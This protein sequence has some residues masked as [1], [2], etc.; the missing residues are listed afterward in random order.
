MK[1]RTAVTGP[2]GEVSRFEYDPEGN[3]RKFIDPN[4]NV[5]TFTYDLAG[6]LT[7]KKYADSK[8]VS[9]VYNKAGLVTQRTDARGI[10]TDYTY[11]VNDNLTTINYSDETPDGTLTYDSFNRLTKMV[12]GTGTSLF[13]YDA[14]GRLTSFDGP[15]ASDT[16]TYTYDE[17]GRPGTLSTQG[18]RSLNYVYDTLNRLAT[19]QDGAEA[20]I[21]SYLN[22]RSPLVAMLT[23]PSGS[24]TEYT[25]SLLGQLTSIHNKDSAGAVISSHDFTYN[26]QDRRD[27]ETISGLL[28]APTPAEGLVEYDYNNLNQLLAKTDPAQAFAYDADGNMTMGYTP[29]GY[30]FTASYDAENRL[31]EIEYTDGSASLRRIEYRYR[32]DSFLAEIR[33]YKN[34]ALVDATRIVRGPYLDLQDRTAENTI[35]NDYLWG[36][37]LGGGIGGL[38]NLRQGSQGYD[39]LYDGIGNVS[40]L[41]DA[42]Q[43]VVASYRYETFGKLL[44]KGGSLDQPFQFSTKRYE[45][46]VG[47]NYYGYRFYAPDLGRWMNR[48]PLGEAG[49]INLYSFVRNNAVNWVDPWG[50]YGTSSC[51]YYKQACKAT[52]R[53]YEC[54]AAQFFCPQFPSGDEGVGNWS[55]CVRQCLQELHKYRNCEINPSDN[56]RDHAY[57]FTSCADNPENPWDPSGP[58]LPDQDISYD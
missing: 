33:R 10:R 17:L 30:V 24:A 51:E 22:A 14:N 54:G 36:L 19:I 40:A 56:A 26:Q 9:Y 28:S 11:D 53:E 13:A 15:L 20:Y 38:L 45:P 32:A 44:A 43:Q 31:K 27:S 5:T 34:T 2:G 41:L 1:R 57:C 47:L 37:N 16:V 29:E 7:A 58:N 39:Y 52:G 35:I 46:S 6:R 42:S 48:D 25:Y 50:L 21:Y 12:D 8:G 55:S 3:V 18:G 4:L 49:G 23:R